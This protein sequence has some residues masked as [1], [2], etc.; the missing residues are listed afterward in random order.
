MTPCEIFPSIYPYLIRKGR[1]IISSLR[2]SQHRNRDPEQINRRIL[3]NV[4]IKW[5]N[6]SSYSVEALKLPD[7][8]VPKPLFFF[9]ILRA[10]VSW[11]TSSWDIVF[12]EFNLLVPYILV[13]F[14]QAPTPMTMIHAPC[15]YGISHSDS[16]CQQQRQGAVD[17][18]GTICHC[19]YGSKRFFF[20]WSGEVEIPQL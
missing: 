10:G 15:G 18:H 13:N 16:L 7:I 14:T 6:F 3:T 1:R 4:K 12:F 20:A 8:I 9:N 17:R 5:S 11:V 19:R 2:P